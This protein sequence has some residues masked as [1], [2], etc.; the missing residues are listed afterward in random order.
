MET[1]RRMHLS[2]HF[3]VWIREIWHYLIY[4][5]KGKEQTCGRVEFSS[6][7]NEHEVQERFPGE[8]VEQTIKENVRQ[9]M[10]KR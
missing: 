9:K 6:E 1:K 7:H 4:G 10:E 8:E 5:A 3:W 2:L